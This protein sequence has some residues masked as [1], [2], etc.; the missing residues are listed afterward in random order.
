[1]NGRGQYGARESAS[2]GI[3][4]F[5]TVGDRD[6][7]VERINTEFHVLI[8]ELEHAMGVDPNDLTFTAAYQR[9]AAFA[10]AQKKKELSPLYPLW[11]DVVS[12]VYAEFRRFYADQSSWTQFVTNW[13]EYENWMNRFKALRSK[14]SEVL[15]A[16][17]KDLTSP[18]PVALPTTLPGDIL[19]ATGEGIKGAA[20][21]AKRGAE[22]AG[23]AAMDAVKIA[24]YA[25]IGVLA[26]GGVIALTSVASH[27][28]KGTDPIESYGALAERGFKAYG[29]R[30]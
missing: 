22:G 17:G 3:S 2:V 28:R 15:K 18:G 23:E 12:P 7:A 19:E 20:G 25:A 29:G 21:L 16:H 24:K 13:E 4:L 10:A 11:R 26:I 6:R 30:S 27:L 14:A 1:M 5:H 9:P 8:S